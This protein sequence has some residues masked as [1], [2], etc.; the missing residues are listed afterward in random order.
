MTSHRPTTFPVKFLHL[1]FIAGILLAADVA[2]AQ[3]NLVLLISQPGDYIGQGQT[4]ITTNASDFSA[5]FNAFGSQQ[6]IRVI[7][8]GFI[9]TFGG[10]GG[11]SLA[12][13][14]YTN[15]ARFPFNGSAPGLSVFGNG[16]A[17]N[18]DCGN[19]KILEIHADNGGNLDRLWLTYTQNCECSSAPLTGE[20][21]FNSRLAP[22]TPVA[23]TLQVPV[24]YPTIQ[25]GINAASI[26]AI[27]TVLVA[28]GV[29][30]ESVQFGGKPAH[31]VGKDGPSQTFIMAPTGL[32]AVTFGNGETA[33]AIVCGF[34][35]T[36]SGTGVSVG[37]NASATIVSNI[38]VNCG[39]GINCGSGSPTICNNSIIGCSG[40]AVSLQFTGAPLI[41]GNL[42]QGNGG[43]IGMWEAGSPTIY[44][45]VIRGNQGD[46]L[47]MVNYSDANIIQ[48]EIVD[49]GGNGIYCLTPEG[50]R[51]PL[52]FNNTHRRQWWCRP[53][54]RRVW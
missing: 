15:A 51:G 26:L 21:R 38:I 8:F 7:A 48:N 43:G 44:N 13:A 53:F 41:E 4:Y 6:D 28:P 40:G 3:S 52:I 12:V 49:N 10:P 2:R 35:L 47:N 31:L 39:T 11:A 50:A 34:T 20:I 45:N 16:R 19:F 32:A 29:Y 1:I 30:N 5:S 46:A 17:C 22:P 42:I 24:D 33:D 37:G 27:D 54:C 14:T 9:M 18:S 23:R 36:N 25:A